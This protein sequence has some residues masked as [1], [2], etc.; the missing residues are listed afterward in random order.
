MMTAPTGGRKDLLLDAA[1]SGWAASKKSRG[2]TTLVEDSFVVLA[3][4][5]I[6]SLWVSM[7]MLL[8]KYQVYRDGLSLGV[9]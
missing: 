8:G 4:L 3:Q 1:H 2:I 5:R 6:P 7:S 9:L